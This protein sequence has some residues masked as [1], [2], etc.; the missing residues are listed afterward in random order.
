[1]DFVWNDVVAKASKLVELSR[2]IHLNP[3]KDKAGGFLTVGLNNIGT[4]LFS[5]GVG[6]GI[7]P[8]KLKTYWSLSREK[9]FRTQA[10]FLRDS[11]TVSSWRTRDE[12]MERYGGG[13]IFNLDNEPYA[14]SHIISF[15]GLAEETDEAV[16]LVLGKAFGL[17]DERF[18]ERVLGISGN[19]V[20]RD[21]QKVY[22]ASEL[23]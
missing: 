16:S 13:V 3:R 21:L 5:E 4:G 8:A 11:S 1:M 2:A 14:S 18:V 20:Y 15:S 22:D 12:G 17:T 7:S 19:R 6:E 9:A 10:D 23:L